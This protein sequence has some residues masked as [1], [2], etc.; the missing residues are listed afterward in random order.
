M[1]IFQK[2]QYSN[3]PRPY[4][5]SSSYYIPFLNGGNPEPTY[6]ADALY[7]GTYQ[8]DNMNPKYQY[9]GNMEYPQTVQRQNV[10]LVYYNPKPNL[11]V[12][13]SDPSSLYYYTIHPYPPY[14]YW[15]PNPN[16]CRDVCGNKVCEDYYNQMNNYRNCTR[17][18]KND[19]PQC[20]SSKKQQCVNCPPE[21]AL[22]GCHLRTRYGIPNPN[23]ELHADLPPQNPLYTSC[24]LYRK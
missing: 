14:V 7:D 10:P 22:E 24:K 17:C 15:Y 2:S 19:P 3:L 23:G 11:Y 1:N 18:Q 5:A 12:D 4:R 21:K 20:W 8:T 6:P 9:Y 16:E 13:A